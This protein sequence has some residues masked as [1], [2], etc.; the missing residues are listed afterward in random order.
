MKRR[1]F[2]KGAGAVSVMVAGGTV[3]RAWD[4]GVIGG[5]PDAAYTP[6]HSWRTATDGGPL[7]LVR[8]AILAASPHNTQPWRFRIGDGA[9]DV[10]ADDSRHLGSMDPYR[11]EMH[12]GLGCV[13]ENMVQ[14]APAYGLQARVTLVPG[15]LVA[16]GGPDGDPVVARL[17]LAP[18]PQRVS[19]LFKA[20][21][22]RHTDRGPYD[23]DRL[24]PADVET[25]LARFAGGH[26]DPDFTLLGP[27]AAR[28]RFAE[29][30]IEA[31]ERIGD[32][33]E[34]VHDSHRW[35]RH[36]YEAIE[37]HRDGVTLA[38]A[39]LSPALT[40][41]AR[42]LPRPSAAASHGYWL[43]STRNVQVPTAAAFGLISVADPYERSRAVRVGRAWQRMHLWATSR[44][45]A[46]QPI[47]QAPEIADRERQLGREAR[48]AGKLR[49]FRTGTGLEPTFAFRLGHPVQSALESP[50][51]SLDAVMV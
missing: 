28:D 38:T 43:D 16:G 41:V 44:G 26:E 12:I 3:W 34:M 29:L 50:R 47:N 18:G 31:T 8:A 48:M 5:P 6:W 30:V 42:I 39:G 11:R 19:P 27:G 4:Q 21:P 20:I 45:L 32:D 1:S 9:I 10:L 46:A 17:R 7:A 49:G 51:R 25:T 36:D 40:A 33:S 35:Y 23:T 24:L 13:I 37:R 2:I 14:A 15:R 22:S